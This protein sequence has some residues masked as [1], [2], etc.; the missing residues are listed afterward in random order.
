MFDW[1]MQGALAKV[2][3]DEMAEARMTLVKLKILAEAPNVGFAYV[4]GVRKVAELLS[5]RFGLQV[6]DVVL[7]RG[8]NAAQLDDASEDLLVAAKRAGSRLGSDRHPTRTSARSYSFGCLLLH[9]LYRL[10]ALSEQAPVR[11]RRAVDELADHYTQFARSFADTPG[12]VREFLRSYDE[13]SSA[14]PNTKSV[15]AA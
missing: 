6:R 8:L 11:Q 3:N 14:G 2:A 12:G 1:L 10:K 15:V 5:Q 13:G 9:H 7:G 4:D